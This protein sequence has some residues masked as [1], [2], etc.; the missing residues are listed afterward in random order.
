MYSYLLVYTS[1]LVRN[2]FLTIYY[3]CIL[4]ICSEYWER[5]DVSINDEADTITYML[6]RSFFFNQKD[7]GCRSESDM[8]TMVNGALVVIYFIIYVSQN[9]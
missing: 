7:T 4:L 6:K 1:N 9:P 8:V 5:E 3:K 2:R